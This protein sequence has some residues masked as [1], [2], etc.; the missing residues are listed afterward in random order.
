MDWNIKLFLSVCFFYPRK[1]CFR[2]LIETWRAE[3]ILLDGKKGK[4]LK[5]CPFYKNNRFNFY[6]PKRRISCPY[7]FISSFAAPGF[8]IKTPHTMIP[9]PHTIRKIGHNRLEF[10]PKINASTAIA[11]HPSAGYLAQSVA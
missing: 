8:L 10:C 9:A 7:F 3:W 5:I 4:Y 11:K 6:K 1:I 2:L